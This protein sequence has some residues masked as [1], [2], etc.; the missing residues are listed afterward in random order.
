[1]PALLRETNVALTDNQ[2]D[3][4]SR[5]IIVPHVGGV[6]QARLLAATMIMAGE[7]RDLEGP[8]A[9]LVGAGVGS[10]HLRVP[11]EQ[12]AT[13]ENLISDMRDLN[14]DVAVSIQKESSAKIELAMILI[15]SAASLELA[16]SSIDEGDTRTFVV[17]RMDTTR[18]IA[19]LPGKS[20]CPRCADAGLLS[21]LP[22]RSEIA[23][24]AMPGAI[25]SRSES[26]DFIAMLATAEAFKLLAGFAPNPAPTLIEFDGFRTNCRP[27]A[28]AAGC[29]CVQSL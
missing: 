6:G 23:Y 1:V 21:N 9:Y 19:I 3:R 7:L 2:I 25:Y 22:Y 8:L 5:Q 29:K 12:I 13:I 4:Y 14:P 26:A 20:P 17:A 18:R 27:L 15:C 28:R 16:Q 11:P 10:I 24:P